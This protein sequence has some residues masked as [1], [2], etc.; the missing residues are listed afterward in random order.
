M[1]CL[2]YFFIIL[3]SCAIDAKSAST[4]AAKQMSTVNSCSLKSDLFSPQL[5]FAELLEGSS[6]HL[7]SGTTDL[8]V[9][10][11]FLDEI[12]LKVST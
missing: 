10:T 9:S 6:E 11:P 5:S 2:S 3:Q 1:L 7:F 8:A 12:F 4:A